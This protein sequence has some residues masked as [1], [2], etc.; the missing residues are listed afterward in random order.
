MST[1]AGEGSAKPGGGRK[2]DP[3]KSK[4]DELYTR[5]LE[6]FSTNVFNQTDLVGLGVAKD[7]TELLTLCQELAGANMFQIMTMDGA[8][9]YK[10]RRKDDADK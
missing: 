9:C 2:K 4:R 5:C 10:A 3:P 6:R 1:P 7:L 8:V